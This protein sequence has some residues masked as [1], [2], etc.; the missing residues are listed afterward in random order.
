MTTLNNN[1]DDEQ[2]HLSRVELYD[3]QKSHRTNSKRRKPRR[4]GPKKP[5]FFAS[6]FGGPRRPKRP[7]R[8]RPVA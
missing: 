1:H 5:G 4:R 6:L 8:R 2:Q 7:K 3:T